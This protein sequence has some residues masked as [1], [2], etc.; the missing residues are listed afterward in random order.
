MKEYD[1]VVIGSGPGGYV[2]AIRCAQLGLNTALVEKYKNLG[3]TCLNVG[4]IPSKAWLD[5]SER[6]HSLVHSV[7][8]HGILIKD[9][10]LDFIRMGERVKNVVR[11][12]SDGIQFLMKKNNI[13]IY[14]GTGSLVNKNVISIKKANDKKETQI[15]S[16]NIVLGTGSKP[17]TI[18][19]VNIDKKDVITS[20]EAL[21]L[22]KLPKQL[23]IIGGGI[24]GLELGSVY[25]RL[26]SEVTVIEYENR[27][28]SNMDEDLGKE[29]LKSLKK[30]GIKFLL[31]HKVLGVE[32]EKGKTVII[33]EN[34]R[35]EALRVQGDKCLVC[36]G[37]KAYTDGLGLE[38]AGVLVRSDGK[39]DVNEYNQTSTKNIFALGDVTRGLMLAHKAEEEGVYVAEIISGQQPEINH[40][41]IPNVVYTW[42]EVA[43]VGKTEKELIDSGVEYKKGSFPFKASGR[44]RASNESEGFIKVLSDKVNDEI[45]GVHMIGPRVADLISE[46]VV[47]LEYRASAEDIA[48]T[49]HAHP[50]YAETF[51]EACLAA[52]ENRAI[53]I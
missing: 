15:S 23:M 12:T 45:L 6:F 44:A 34:L 38:N 28:I 17:T 29:L 49:C 21:Y 40:S 35:N 24:I 32:K 7:S 46:A 16:K 33:A 27:I 2:C 43:S 31:N 9:V 20:S 51:K 36:V 10:K 53:H 48:R 26:G 4:C 37:R 42:P 47:A 19:G 13:D 30:I 5:S 25:R 14:N 50:T 22:D 1:V 3:G 41:L 11:Q 39:I 52:T 8:D 18:P